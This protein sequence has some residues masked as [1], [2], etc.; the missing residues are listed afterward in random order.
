MN[1]PRRGGSWMKS[2]SQAFKLDHIP[3]AGTVPR[4]R[5]VVLIHSRTSFIVVACLVFWTNQ[6]P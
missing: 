5:Q 6:L 2:R 3:A 4:S 1:A